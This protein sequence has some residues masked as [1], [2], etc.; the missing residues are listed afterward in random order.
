MSDERA[1]EVVELGIDFNSPVLDMNDQPMKDEE[2]H[3]IRLGAVCCNALMAQIRDDKADGVQRLK[4]FNLARKIQGSTEE[5][6][7]PRL[8]LNSKQ[9]KM[10]EELAEKCYGTLVYARIY[11][12]LEGDTKEEEE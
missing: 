3:D 1:T 11:E 2:G 4:R 10:I 12:A 7:F 8:R 5:E 6:D 9:K